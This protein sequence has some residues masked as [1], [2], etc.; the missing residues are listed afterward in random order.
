MIAIDTETGLASNEEPVPVLVSVAVCDGVRTELLAAH[1]PAAKRFAEAAYTHGAI[2][3]NAPFDAYVI[4]RQWPDLW[5]LIVDAYANDRVVDVLTREKMID[6]AEGTARGRKYNLG[7]VADRRASIEVNKDD[8]WRLRYIELLGREILGWPEGAGTYAIR[9]PWATFQVHAAQ[10]LFRKTHAADVFKDAA[11]TARAHLALYQQTLVGMETDPAAVR[12]LDLDWQAQLDALAGRLMF[13]GLARI[14]GTK[15]APKLQLCQKAAK[16][17]AGALP[18]ATT[19]EKGNVS[20]SSENLAKLQLPKDH[21]LDLYRQFDDIRGWQSNTIPVFSHPVIRTRYDVIKLTGR[22]GSS[23]PQW[24]RK[25]ADVEPWEWVGRN[26]QNLPQKGGVRECLRAR[27][28]CKLVISDWGGMELVTFAQIALGLFG[29]SRMAEVLQAGGSP[30]NEFAAKIVGV[31]LDV[32]DRANPEHKTARDVAKIYNFGKLGGMGVQRFQAF[33][34]AAGIHKTLPEVRRLNG[35]FA[36]TWP[37]VP[38]YFE[39]IA[40]QASA[41]GFATILQPRSGLIHGKRTF[42][43]ACNLLFQGLAASA[44]KLALW[45]LWLAGRDPDSPLFGCYQ[46]LFVHDENVTECP[47]DRAEA[48]LAEQERIMIAAV[49]V[50]CPDVPISVDSQIVERY[51]K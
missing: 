23:A 34:A 37:E 13:H 4:G 50:W 20:I 3:A 9:D 51:C 42:P 31:P 2:L 49:A 32:F 22:T 18:G 40:Q 33:L 12:A 36:E 39:Y 27:P 15:K 10:E 48:V 30:H 8:P 17:L 45:W 24:P 29:R 7:D 28:G 43:E 35:L 14:G 38:A 21:P 41:D 25:P 44:A 6:M 11:N 26:L 46:V 5:P 16:E 19:T 47:A 1:D